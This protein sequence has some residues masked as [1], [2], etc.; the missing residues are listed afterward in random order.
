MKY[1]LE[2]ILKCLCFVILGYFV[3]MIFGR[4]C[5]CNNGFSVGAPSFPDNHCYGLT[6]KEMCNSMHKLHHQHC[7]W[8][9]NPLEE[10]DRCCEASENQFE[11]GEGAH[12]CKMNNTKLHRFYLDPDGSVRAKGSG[13]LEEAVEEAEEVVEEVVE[14][15]V[16]GAAGGGAADY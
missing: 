1:D 16:G 13:Y 8:A 10:G 9:I 12:T 3:A 5:S 6:D 14:E 4:M 7:K 15:A 2:E 11:R